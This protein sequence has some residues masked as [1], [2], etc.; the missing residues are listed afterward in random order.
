MG[1]LALIHALVVNTVVIRSVLDVR[2]LRASASNG[3]TAART[4]AHRAHVAATSLRLTRPS[5]TR[6]ELNA[7]SR[8]RPEAPPGSTIRTRFEV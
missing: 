1:T 3:L 6:T 7:G 5:P 2:N 4:H 8:V